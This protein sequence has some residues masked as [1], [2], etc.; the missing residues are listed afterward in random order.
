[1]LRSSVSVRVEEGAVPTAALL[2]F[3]AKEEQMCGGEIRW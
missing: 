3:M 1:M 2:L